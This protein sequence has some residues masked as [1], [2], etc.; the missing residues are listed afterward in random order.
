MGKKKKH[1]TEGVKKEKLA[2]EKERVEKEKDVL[3]D[4]LQKELEILKDRIKELEDEVKEWKNKYLYTLADYDNLRKRKKKELEEG[5][6]YANERFL[7]E[8]LTV[9]DNF[10]RAMKA[11]PDK[12]GEDVEGIKKGVEMIYRH[13][14]EFLKREG[15]VPFESEGKSFDPQKHE[16]LSVVEDDTIPPGTVVQEHEKGYIYK[17]R[18]LRPARVTVSVEK[19]EEERKEV[20]ENEGTDNRDRS[21]ND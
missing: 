14:M 17:N 1:T 11:M 15:V 20:I 19:K 13:F 10:E 9:V 6:R 18:I 8:L 21:G 2:P 12:G 3:I 5:I 7:R 4:E 16:A